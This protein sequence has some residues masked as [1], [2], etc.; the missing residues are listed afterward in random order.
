MMSPAM[1]P[2]MPAIMSAAANLVAVDNRFDMWRG[3]VE[4]WFYGHLFYGVCAVA[5]VTETSVQ[6]ALPINGWLS[7]VTFVGAV[8]FYS[9]PYTRRTATSPDPRVVWHRQHRVLVR[10]FQ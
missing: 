1:A 7:L 8:L 10:R 9:Y 6:L 3:A 5:Q 4:A 2:S